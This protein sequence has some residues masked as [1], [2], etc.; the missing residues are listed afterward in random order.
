MSWFRRSFQDIESRLQELDGGSMSDLKELLDSA[1]IAYGVVDLPEFN[2]KVM[3]FDVGNTTYTTEDDDDVYLESLADTLLFLSSRS[4]YH[5][6]N[7]FENHFPPVWEMDFGEY[8][9]NYGYHYT[10]ED[11]LPKIFVE[12]LTPRD[13]TRGISNRGTGL[14]V[15][16][17][18]GMPTYSGD[19]LLRIDVPTMKKDGYLPPATLEEP[20][21]EKM[22]MEDIAR[23][24]GKENYEHYLEQ[25]YEENTIVVFGTI[26]PKYISVDNGERM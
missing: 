26:P 2:R 6:E 8:G 21:M 13:E 23:R 15:F 16:L 12:G 1:G 3:Y 17:S 14:A 20:V 11:R 19:V 4:G 9:D 5:V 22:V 25:G 10:Y 18:M 24:F 7:Y